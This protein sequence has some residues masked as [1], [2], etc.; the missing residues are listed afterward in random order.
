M[1][2]Q[3]FTQK[4]R[5]AIMAAQTMALEYQNQTLEQDHVLHALLDQE[6]SL[7]A[8]LFKKMDVEPGNV[9]VDLAEGISGFP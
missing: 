2:L 4:S 5:D 9:E 1:D 7:I 3:K 8:Q 6:N